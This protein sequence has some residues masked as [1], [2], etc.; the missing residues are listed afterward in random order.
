MGFGFIKASIDKMLQSEDVLQKEA[1][2]SVLGAVGKYC[3]DELKGSIGQILG[4]VLTTAKSTNNQFL[5]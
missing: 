2:V 1:A 3:F 5:K 4:Y